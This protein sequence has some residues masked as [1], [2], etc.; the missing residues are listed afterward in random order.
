MPIDAIVHYGL[1]FNLRREL[2]VEDIRP[3]IRALFHELLAARVDYL[4]VGGVAMLCHIAG[5]NTQ[6]ID[7][8]VSPN[9]LAKMEWQASVRD[10]DFGRAQYRGLQV[11]LLLTSN[12]LFA[13]VREHERT[14]VQFDGLTIPCATRE[15]LSLL[16]L[17]ALPSLYRHG[18]LARAA[19]YE[20]DLAML[21][22]GVEIDDERLLSTLGGHL[23]AADV[24]ELRGILI[25]QKGRRRFQ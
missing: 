1:A 18:H 7:L 2:S 22:Q 14:A 16:K 5:R 10:A 3:T 4:L 13:F 20:A 8:I 15:G 24:G 25:E 17:Y 19:L 12:P 21:H 9:D 11:D 23:S 6:D